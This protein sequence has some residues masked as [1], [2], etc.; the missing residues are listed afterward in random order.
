[1]GFRPYSF[2]EMPKLSRARETKFFAFYQKAKSSG[3]DDEISY[4]LQQ[5]PLMLRG[6]NCW[7]FLRIMDTQGHNLT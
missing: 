4:Y 1:M 5:F 7:R 2:T 3:Y 6:H